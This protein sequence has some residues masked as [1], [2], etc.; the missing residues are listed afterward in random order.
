MLRIDREREDRLWRLQRLARQR[1]AIRGGADS[2]FRPCS[3]AY[4][5]PPNDGNALGVV[6]DGCSRPCVEQ[7]HLGYVKPS[8]EQ[9]EQL[10]EK[11]F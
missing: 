9:K 8:D 1:Q 3:A 4:D 11:L 7:I 2:A 10:A 5:A 6:C